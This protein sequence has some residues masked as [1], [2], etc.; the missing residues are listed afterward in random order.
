MQSKEDAAEDQGLK[1]SVLLSTSENRGD[2]AADIRV[3][4]DVRPGETVE[5][6]VRR[7]LFRRRGHPRGP[8]PIPSDHIE[9]RVVVESPEAES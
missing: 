9:L 4:H 1:I 5:E 3:A 7:L 2:H 6:M 8:Q